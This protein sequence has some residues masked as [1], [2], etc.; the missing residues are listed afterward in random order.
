MQ[1]ITLQLSCRAYV[2]V[3]GGEQRSNAGYTC[4]TYLSE[5]EFPEE[6]SLLLSLSEPEP[7]PESESE[8]FSTCNVTTH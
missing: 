8:R 4:K 3:S 1:S 2:V 5:A 7:D 6:E